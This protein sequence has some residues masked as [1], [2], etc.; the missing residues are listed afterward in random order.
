MRNKNMAVIYKDAFGNKN[1]A[2]VRDSDSSMSDEEVKALFDK[3]TILAVYEVVDVFAMA[4]VD[5]ANEVIDEII[6]EERG[7]KAGK[8]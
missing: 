5:L 2:E 7:C 4:E 1:W 8:L 6:E 3:Q